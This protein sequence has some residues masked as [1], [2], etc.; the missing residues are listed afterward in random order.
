MMTLKPDSLQLLKRLA[1]KPARFGYEI[2]HAGHKTPKLVSA[3]HRGIKGKELS[4]LALEGYLARRAIDD[5]P[6]D[7]PA[8]VVTFTLTAKGREALGLKPER[9]PPRYRRKLPSESEMARQSL[10]R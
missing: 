10:A 2:P 1:D 9:P 8:I 5:G 4:A 3:T 7:E 6:R